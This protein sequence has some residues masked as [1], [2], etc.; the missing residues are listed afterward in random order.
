VEGGAGRRG[1]GGE[2]GEGEGDLLIREPLT[3][4]ETLR[5]W[6]DAEG[7][8]PARAL[9]L[10]EDPA[11]GRVITDGSIDEVV[12]GLRLEREGKLRAIIRSPNPRAEF[13]E[14]GGK[15]LRW[16]VKSFRS[17]VKN[18]PWFNLDDALQS[19]GK[20]LVDGVNVI[21]DTAYLSE[22]DLTA[23]RAAVRE[24][25]WSSQIIYGDSS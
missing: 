4:E 5:V 3:R 2:E 11:K 18:E 1:G 13:I 9:R 20:K 16:D 25:G 19:I 8:D 23:L 12:V 10:A 24:H 15:G 7:F 14:D 21:I 22:A 6:A 17:V